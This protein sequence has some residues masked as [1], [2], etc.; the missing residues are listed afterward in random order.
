MGHDAVFGLE[1]NQGLFL[2]PCE[3]KQEEGPLALRLIVHPEQVVAVEVE[4]DGVLSELELALS[5]R[6]HSRLL[7]V[8]QSDGSQFLAV[9]CLLILRFLLVKVHLEHTVLLLVQ[10]GESPL[11]GGLVLL[12]VDDI[13][14]AHGVQLR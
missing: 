8:G 6:L 12:F 9:N 3:I 4:R 1:D 13:V 11:T 7:Q 14:D 5:I 2:V 10:Q